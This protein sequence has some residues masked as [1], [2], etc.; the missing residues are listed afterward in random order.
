MENKTF[1][2]SDVHQ[3]PH[4]DETV[5][6]FDIIVAPTI[7]EFNAKLTSYAVMGFT[8]PSEYCFWKL[9]N[10]TGTTAFIQFMVRGM[11]RRVIKNEDELN[12]QILE[13]R[14]AQCLVEGFDAFKS[15]IQQLLG[16]GFIF[17]ALIEG[18]Q[19]MVRYREHES[20]YP[21]N[22]FVDAAGNYIN[23]AVGTD[24]I[25]I[26]KNG[27]YYRAQIIEIK[28]PSLVRVHFV[29]FESMW[30]CDVEVKAGSIFSTSTLHTYD[31]KDRAV[32]ITKSIKY[33]KK[34]NEIPVKFEDIF[35]VVF[36]D[37]FGNTVQIVEGN[38]IIAKDIVSQ[39]YY[40]SIIRKIQDNKILVH[41]E[42]WSDKW[43]IWIDVKDH[44][45]FSLLSIDH[46]E[47]LLVQ[48][49]TAL[50]LKNPNAKRVKKEKEEN[51]KEE[52]NKAEQ[53]IDEYDNKINLVVGERIIAK[54][55]V[56]KYFE[57]TILNVV[58]RQIKV[59]YDGW[60]DRWD[61]WINV[62]KKNIFSLQSRHYITVSPKK[63]NE[64]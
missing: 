11:K 26:D 3:P 52:K 18:Y 40:V 23:I 25:A 24:V 44:N 29:D 61:E 32:T 45:V 16:F 20:D 59:H 1:T 28:A 46:F 54:D 15:Q 37:I 58:E 36:E 19:I 22:L 47:L 31:A 7:E 9:K 30:D 35:E 43:D 5:P 14:Y 12:T 60:N 50:I 42:E 2:S 57:A 39:K 56:G 10:E 41:Y 8:R 63:I 6:E 21:L 38:R 62:N 55:T 51:K 53:F 34:E 27:R 4:Y 17:G 64:K 33:E 49:R 13:F 48:N